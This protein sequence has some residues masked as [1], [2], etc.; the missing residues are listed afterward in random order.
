MIKKTITYVDY[1][2]LER[3]ESF[4]FHLT[5]T[6][7]LEMEIGTDGGL[8]EM[9]EKVVAAN[10]AKAIV[11]IFKDLVFKAYGE[12]SLD[13]KRFVKSEELSVA[14]SQ[15]EAYSKLFMELATNAEKAAEFVNGVIP[16]ELHEKMGNKIPT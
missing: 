2:G 13:G 6:E 3:T 14:F 10:E 15:T 8:V 11:K 5:E 12:K 16:K 7:L 9:I 1:N 4:Y